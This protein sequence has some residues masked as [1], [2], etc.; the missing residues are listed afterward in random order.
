[1]E[2]AASKNKVTENKSE[3]VK[4]Q[5]VFQHLVKGGGE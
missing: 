4:K 5:K 2:I 1:M 3:Q